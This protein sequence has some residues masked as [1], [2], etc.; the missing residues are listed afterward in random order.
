[1][2]NPA[3]VRRNFRALGAATHGGGTTAARRPEPVRGRPRGGRASA[4]GQPLGPGAGTSGCAR[5]APSQAHRTTTQAQSG[6]VARHRARAQTRPWSFRLCHRVVDREQGAWAHRVSDRGALP[7][8]PRLA[9]P[10]P[11][12]LDLPTTDRQRRWSATRRRFGTGS[13]H[14]GPRL[15][16]S[17]PRTAHYRLHRRK[18]IERAPPS[19]ADPGAARADAG[20]PISLQL[21]SAVGGG[22][23]HLVELLLPALSCSRQR[24]P[25]LLVKVQPRQLTSRPGSISDGRGGN[26]STAS[27]DVY[28]LRCQVKVPNGQEGKQTGGP[29]HKGMPAVSKWKSRGKPF[30]GTLRG[31]EPRVEGRRPKST[32]KNWLDALVEPPV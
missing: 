12:Q 7:P 32:G 17:P 23:S 10:A 26:E 20:A 8:G 29:Q 14:A 31:A 24:L 30:T 18:W 2:G 4:I 19:R 15:K 13:S 25:F 9:H 5:T 21:E 3:G 22:G 6:A 27:S 1:M 28:V 16:K 11:A